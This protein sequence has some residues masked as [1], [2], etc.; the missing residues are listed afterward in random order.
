MNCRVP[1]AYPPYKLYQT[2]PPLGSGYLVSSVRE[3]REG[4]DVRM[5]DFN[6][7]HEL[8][9]FPGVVEPLPGTELYEIAKERGWLR[10]FEWS[11]L[12]K[13]EDR[14]VVRTE[15][16]STRT[17]RGAHDNVGN[18][19]QPRQ[20]G[21]DGG[22]GIASPSLVSQTGV[23]GPYSIRDVQLLRESRQVELTETA[24]LFISRA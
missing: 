14:T 15:E 20:A 7:K 4:T 18:R 23:G 21:A 1:P 9:S 16:L 2:V 12:L 11:Q 24:S 22:A 13:A 10:D 8:N 5:I 3:N 6:L 17:R 19:S